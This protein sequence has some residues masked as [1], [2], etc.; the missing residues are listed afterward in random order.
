LIIGGAVDALKESGHTEERIITLKFKGIPIYL[1]K[2]SGHDWTKHSEDCA[3]VYRDAGKLIAAVFDGVSGAKDGTGGMAARKAAE[4]LRK[5]APAITVDNYANIMEGWNDEN[6]QSKG[7]GGATTALVFMEFPGKR[8]LF[9]KGDCYGFVDRGGDFEE[10]T[11]INIEQKT[12]KDYRV[13]SVLGD[14]KE[15][16]SREISGEAKVLELCSDGVDS[17]S[18]DCAIV[19]VD[20]R[21]SAA[22]RISIG[23]EEESP[24]PVDNT[25]ESLTTTLQS[26]S[27]PERQFQCLHE[28]QDLLNKPFEASDSPALDQLAQ[29]LEVK[30][31]DNL[32]ALV[33]SLQAKIDKRI[34]ELV[35]NPL[36]DLYDYARGIIKG[37][38]AEGESQQSYF[39]AIRRILAYVKDHPKCVNW[40]SNPRALPMLADALEKAF[41]QSEWRDGVIE[42][43]RDDKDG[44]VRAA[45][46]FL[47][48]GAVK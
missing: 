42:R 45:L 33:T 1:R 28:L 4:T 32:G 27:D 17:P 23:V 38:Y 15:F 18:D 3:L 44:A 41:D 31:N 30:R 14:G 35:S 8:V 9:N 7:A 21:G 10:A 13:V 20:L 46:E 2:G 43:L 11:S 48:A 16:G 24:P 12:R 47:Q 36:A 19:R 34:A 5:I 26:E 39:D 6:E 37:E 29:V 40:E 22:T 25:I